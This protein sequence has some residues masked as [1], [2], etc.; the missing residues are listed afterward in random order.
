M[1]PMAGISFCLLVVALTGCGSGTT[2]ISGEGTYNGVAIEN[3]YISFSPIGSGRS[4]AGP[5]AN[6]KYTIAEAI[7]G[8]YT[9]VIIGSR[10]IDH[11]SSSADAYANSG[12]NAGHIS[13]ATDYIAQD[14][15]GNS[16]EVEITSGEQKMDFAITGPPMPK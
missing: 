4:I 15:D 3:G 2:S 7:P 16:K 11:Y 13:E 12:P 5:I 1:R 9:A 10:K 6:G 8:K 14:A